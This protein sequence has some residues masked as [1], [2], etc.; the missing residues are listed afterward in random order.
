MYFEI[1][2]ISISFLSNVISSKCVKKS[3][4]KKLKYPYEGL[5]DIIHDNIKPIP[6]YYPDRF[7]YFLIFLTLINLQYLIKIISMVFLKKLILCV[8]LCLLLRSITIHLTLFPSCIPKDRINKKLCLYDSSFLSSHDFM[9]SG[10]TILY[11]FFSHLL[12]NNLIQIIGPFLSIASRQHYTIDVFVSFV[13]FYFI[14][15]NL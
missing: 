10:H 12:N 8:G 2:L 15:Q 13:V 5:P 7:M 9:F 14:Y 3:A 4:E 6:F 1:I 11:I